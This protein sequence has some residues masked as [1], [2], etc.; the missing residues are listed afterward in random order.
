MLSNYKVGGLTEEVAFHHS[1]TP[2]RPV[3]TVM[4]KAVMAVELMAERDIA[5]VSLELRDY[6]KIVL[7]SMYLPPPKTDVEITYQE[8]MD[9]SSDK[10]VVVVG[11]FNSKSS[12]WRNSLHKSD[13]CSDFILKFCV[14]N[15]LFILNDPTSGLCLAVPRELAGSTKLCAGSEHRSK[16]SAGNSSLVNQQPNIAVLWTISTAISTEMPIL[17]QPKYLVGRRTWIC[18][19]SGRAYQKR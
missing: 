18:H 3:V 10:S 15:D 8:E 19:N 9:S 5:A 4:I 2:A 7:V 11:D 13:A 6:V 12:V 16:W 1:M 17:S 14:Q